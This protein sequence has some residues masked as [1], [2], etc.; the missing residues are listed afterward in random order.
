M[1]PIEYNYT[2][3]IVVV[4]VYMIIPVIKYTKKS[5]EL[6]I[7]KLQSS[8]CREETETIQRISTSVFSSTISKFTLFISTIVPILTGILGIIEVIY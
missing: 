1:L 3:L 5:T 2:L 7:W 6:K 8:T 4:I